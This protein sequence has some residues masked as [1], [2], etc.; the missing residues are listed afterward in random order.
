MRVKVGKFVVRHNKIEY[1][2]NDVFE[3]DTEGGERLIDKGVAKETSEAVSKKETETKAD[4]AGE[5]SIDDLTPEI[6]N[7][8]KQKELLSVAKR[9]DLETD[10]NKADTLRVAILVAISDEVINLDTMD[11]AA[12]RELADEEEITLPD[13]ADAEAIRDILAEALVD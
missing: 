9:M 1:G 11:E 4:T 5:V 12:M 2:E 8:L 7:K 6:V 13:D 10:D 3:I